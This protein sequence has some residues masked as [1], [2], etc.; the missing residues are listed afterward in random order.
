MV[1]FRIQYDVT[2]VQQCVVVRFQRA[3][4]GVHSVVVVRFEC[5]DFEVRQR[6]VPR[7]IE[8]NPFGARPGKKLPSA[9]LVV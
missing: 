8:V 7:V 2:M 5:Y 3:G 6:D 1:V 4:K 9:S